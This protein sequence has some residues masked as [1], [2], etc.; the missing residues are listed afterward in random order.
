MMS[1]R[2]RRNST[3]VDGSHQ[4]TIAS[5]AINKGVSLGEALE[6]NRRIVPLGKEDHSISLSSGYTVDPTDFTERSMSSSICLS[7]TGL[8]TVS[9]RIHSSSPKYSRK[10]PSVLPPPPFSEE[11]AEAEVQEMPRK[12]KSTRRSSMFGSTTP[13]ALAKPSPDFSTSSPKVTKPRRRSFFGS[14]TCTIDHDFPQKPLSEYLPK[15]ASNME[16]CDESIDLSPASMSKSSCR[17]GMFKASGRSFDTDATDEHLDNRSTSTRNSKKSGRKL[18]KAF[19]HKKSSKEGHGVADSGEFSKA[20][21][22]SQASADLVDG[23]QGPKKPRSSRR[24]S[25]F[26]SAGGVSKKSQEVVPSQ[27]GSRPPPTPGHA[28]RRRR[29][30]FGNAGTGNQEQGE[31]VAQPSGADSPIRSEKPSF[32]RLL[33]KGTE[34]P[35]ATLT[36]RTNNPYELVNTE[37]IRRQLQP[38]VRSMLLDSV[39]KDVAVQLSRSNGAMCRPTDYHGN[40]GKG[41]D[42]WTIHEKMMAQKGT[43]KANIISSQFYQYGIGM[44]RDKDGQIYLCQL[45]Q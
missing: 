20:T 30:M 11:E 19:F 37:R 28:R 23:D 42:I 2:T 24:H 1:H 44:A 31:R 16:E 5:T 17:G 27:S 32:R 45:F 34:T 41:V 38:F 6:A 21:V 22:D 7:E 33:G 43:E 9:T 10:T 15:K 8:A 36:P 40:I 39:A 29:S 26:G 18:V 4:A 12:P 13:G 3:G 25:L 35:T 14:G